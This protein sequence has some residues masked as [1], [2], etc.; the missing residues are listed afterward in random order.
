MHIDFTHFAHQFYIPTCTSIFLVSFELYAQSTLNHLS[1]H[2]LILR[3]N[4][5][6]DVR[7]KKWGGLIILWNLLLYF[8]LLWPLGAK[9]HEYFS[10]LLSENANT[11]TWL[12]DR[13]VFQR[14]Q[15]YFPILRKACFFYYFRVALKRLA[16]NSSA[17]MCYVIKTNIKLQKYSNVL[18][19]LR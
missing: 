16:F 17:I 9:I 3:I 13:K 1:K 10:V 15:G 11:A 4:Q 8:S 2:S 14:F 7:C 19:K 5:F 12:N 18:L 6:I